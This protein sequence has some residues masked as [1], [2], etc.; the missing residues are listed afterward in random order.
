MITHPTRTARLTRTSHLSSTWAGLA[1]L[2]AP[3][4]QGSLSGHLQ[5]CG[6]RRPPVTALPPCGSCEEPPAEP[7][8]EARADEEPNEYSGHPESHRRGGES[9]A[10]PLYHEGR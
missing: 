4:N 3:L 1:P 8:A 9:E 7:P 10:E 2:S 5:E 6:R